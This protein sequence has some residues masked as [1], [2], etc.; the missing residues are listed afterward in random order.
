MIKYILMIM[1]LSICFYF[2]NNNIIPI[3]LKIDAI[4]DHYIEKF[5]NYK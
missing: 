3:Y 4:T 5:I 1:I 2:V